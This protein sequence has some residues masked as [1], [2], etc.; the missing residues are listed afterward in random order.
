[1]RQ[2]VCLLL[3]TNTE[4]NPNSVFERGIYSHFPI[5]FQ[6]NTILLVRCI[7][8]Q[9]FFLVTKLAFCD[10]FSVN[11][12]SSAKSADHDFYSQICNSLE[13]NVKNLNISV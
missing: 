10:S 7:T 8:E 12:S 1:M 4:L 13:A 3:P 2:S 5:V 9:L 6:S 11:H